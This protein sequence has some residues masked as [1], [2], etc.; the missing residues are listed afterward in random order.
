MPYRRTAFTVAFTV[1]DGLSFTLGTVN[2]SQF[3]VFMTTKPRSL[4]LPFLKP[5]VHHCVSF[6]LMTEYL[7]SQNVQRK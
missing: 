4:T 6:Y 1:R 3:P 5:S 2:H 7:D